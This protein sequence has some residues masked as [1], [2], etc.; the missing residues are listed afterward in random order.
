VSLCNHI[1]DDIEIGKCERCT[2]IV[3]D[4]NKVTM[5][6][7]IRLKMKKYSIKAVPTIIIDGEIKVIIII[8]IIVIPDF[9]QI[10][11][12]DLYT[13]LKRDYSIK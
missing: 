2:Q 8:I 7:D 13:I 6:E 11:G 1:T 9:P 5:T 12:Q 3:Y 10:C 4:I